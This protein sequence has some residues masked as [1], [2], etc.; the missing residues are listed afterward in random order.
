MSRF[1]LT[2]TATFGLEAVVARELEQL[3]YGNLRVTD[4]RV[5]FRGKEVEPKG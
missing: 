4:G 2:A 3:G 5:H 1:H